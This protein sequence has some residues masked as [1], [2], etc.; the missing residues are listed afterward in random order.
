MDVYK[1]SDIS[2]VTVIKNSR[3]LKFVPDHYKT[4]KMCKH[5]V[6]KIPYILRY[7]PD[8]HKS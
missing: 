3:M 1:S 2:A 6:K 4:K 8:E 7:V 5:E